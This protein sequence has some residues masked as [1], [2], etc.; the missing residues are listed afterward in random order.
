MIRIPKNRRSTHPG[1]MLLEEFLLP[2]G[3]TQTRLA[4]EI[5]VP[6]QRI[7]EIISGKRG[8]TA[9]TALRLERFLGVSS[10]FWMNLQAVYDLQIA[11]NK[12]SEVLKSIKTC[13]MTS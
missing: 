7:N 8:L 13:E 10:T 6:F 3:I 12:E 11:Q 2:L 4:E 9:S 5:K 1:E